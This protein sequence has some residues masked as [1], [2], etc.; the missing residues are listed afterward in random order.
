MIIHHD[1]YY[2]SDQARDYLLVRD[3]VLNHKLTLIGS[4]SG[5]GGLFHGPLWLYILVPFFIIGHG[6]PLTFAYWYAIMP[7]LTVLAG[8]FAGKKLYTTNFGLL[9]GFFLSVNSILWGY[10][11]NTIGINLMPL[12]YVFFI[13]FCILYIRGEQKSFIGVTFLAG[14]AFQFETASAIAMIPVALFVLLLNKKHHPNLRTLVYSMMS[15]IISLS[16]FIFFDLRHKF[17]IFKST[18]QIFSQNGGHKD[19]IS[20][21]ERVIDHLNGLK[22]TYF[23]PMFSSDLILGI[24]L[25]CILAYFFYL[26]YKKRIPQLREFLFL[27]LSPLIVYLLFMAYPHPIYREYVLDMTISLIFALSFTF[28]IIYKKLPG[29]ILVILFLALNALYA[30]LYLK[31]TYQTPYQQDLSSGSYQNQKKVVDWI[32]S[33]ANDKQFG[34][35][36]YTPETFTYGVDYLF[37]YESKIKKVQQ[38]QSKKQYVTYLILYPPLNNDSHAHD[39]WI[40]NTINTVAIPEE[41]KQFTG[42]ITVEKMDL[43]S[44]T[45]EVDSNYYQNLIFR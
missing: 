6:N 21:T 25:I 28:S 32:I 45:Q 36:V 7:F 37:W 34:Y 22:D 23:S 27:F 12:L 30:G 16:T 31:N 35:F 33:N 14:L 11:N 3:I 8:F 9:I 17:L 13:Y 24:F 41:T 43:S 39:F 10:I 5:L 19:Y 26:A 29:K 2:L 4:H 44:D 38:P 20:L 15:F 42:G 40:K 18:L 1:F